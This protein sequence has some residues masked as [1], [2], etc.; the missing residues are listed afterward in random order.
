MNIL[1][2]PAQ[3]LNIFHTFINLFSFVF[4]NQWSFLNSDVVLKLIY[5]W[6]TLSNAK[7]VIQLSRYLLYE[8]TSNKTIG[9][10]YSKVYEKLS[11]VWRFT[12]Q[13]TIP[14]ISF[15]YFLPNVILAKKKLFLCL[16]NSVILYCNI[17]GQIF[18]TI[19]HV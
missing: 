12:N 1:I 15:L 10:T 17:T 7:S 8:V 3:Y 5:W 11:C 2:S 6:N 14:R 9:I 19:Y 13:Q 4:I 18:D 16:K